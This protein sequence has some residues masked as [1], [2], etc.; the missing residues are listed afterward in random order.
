[1]NLPVQYN[2]ENELETI[3]A[4][5]TGYLP[6]TFVYCLVNTSVT[7]GGAPEIVK[8]KLFSLDCW[9][10][11]TLHHSLSDKSFFVVLVKTI[12]GFS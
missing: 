10:T 6:V 7:L 12:P 5:V 11:P 3:L 8:N 9:K 1:M 4:K 2:C